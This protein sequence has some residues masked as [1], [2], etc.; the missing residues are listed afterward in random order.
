VKFRGRGE[1]RVASLE[2]RR[3]A[4]QR[5]LDR[6][7][8]KTFNWAEGRTCVHLARHQ[9][10]NMGHRPPS[11]PRFR[12]ALAAKRAMEE[13]GWSSVE[14]MLDSML[15]RITPAQMV[16]GDLAIVEGAA[17]FSSIVV[18]AGPQ[19]VLGWLPSGE[20]VA[21]YAGGVSELTAA[22]RL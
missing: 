11:L 1:T 16:L 21:V 6:Y 13:R 22:W 19:R 3:L 4:T 5:T 20:G 15:P 14:E 18:C 17:G 7:R 10:R 12:S 8:D 9:L 2:W